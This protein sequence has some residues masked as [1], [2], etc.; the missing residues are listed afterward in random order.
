MMRMCVPVDNVLRMHKLQ[1]DQNLSSIEACFV[2]RPWVVCCC[3]LIKQCTTC[4]QAQINQPTQ[5]S[6]TGLQCHDTGVLTAQV[7]TRK[8]LHHKKQLCIG[9]KRVVQPNNK[10]MSSQLPPS[11]RNIM[12]ISTLGE[13][14]ANPSTNRETHD[15]Q[16]P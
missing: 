1:C 5:H 4:M 8:I 13:V 11:R 15:I 14:I 12:T 10:W 7:H 9:L 2:I 3:D 6:S 16:Q